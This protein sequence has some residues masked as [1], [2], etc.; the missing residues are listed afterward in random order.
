MKFNVSRAYIE[1]RPRTQRRKGAEVRGG[2]VSTPLVSGVSKSYVDSNFVTLTTD[3]SIAGIKD[4]LN[5]F[6]IGGVSVKCDAERNALIFPCNVLVEGGVAAFSS[7]NGFKPQTITDAVLIDGNTL[8]RNEN[9]EIYVIGGTG[10]GGSIEYP[11]TWSGYSSGS[12]DGSASKNIA[13]PSLLSQ[14]T[15]DAGFATSAAVIVMLSDYATKDFVTSKGYITTESVNSLLTDYLPKSGGAVSGDITVTAGKIFAPQFLAS[16]AIYVNGGVRDCINIATSAAYPAIVMKGANHSGEVRLYNRGGTDWVLTDEGWGN[17]YPI[18]HSGN[19]SEY[20]FP[21]TGGSVSGAVTINYNGNTPLVINQNNG[22]TSNPRGVIVMNSSLS[23]NNLYISHLFG[24][25]GSTRNSAWVGFYLDSTGSNNNRLSMGLYGVDNVLNVLG[26]G[27]VA[28]GGVTA[29]EKLHVHGNA[30]VTGSLIGEGDISASG[31]VR[32]T[33]YLS[34]GYKQISANIDASVRT[35]IYGDAGSHWG[36]IKTFRT[37]SAASYG[38]L[39][40]AYAAGILF[41][42]ADT[43]A[44]I[45]LPSNASKTDD[46]IIGGGGDDNIRWSAKLLHSL[47]YGNYALPITGGVVSGQVTVTSRFQINT[48]NE[49]RNFGYFRAETMMTNRCLLHIGSSY[50]YGT[51]VDAIAMYRGLVGIGRTFTSDEMYNTQATGTRL[52]VAGNVI[53]TGG[54]TA[55]NI[56]DRRLKENIRDFDAISILIGMG[57]VHAYEYV[58][59]E[60]ARDARYAGTHYGFIYQNVEGSELDRM[61]LKREDGYGALN[62]LDSNLISVV[63]GGVLSLDN[64]VKLLEHENEQLREEINRLKTSLS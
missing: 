60:V 64:R 37:G 36:Q 30:K 7:I 11:L 10:G 52:Y 34:N 23:N 50:S 41:A 19:Y 2:S 4:F 39:S 40:G 57:G 16:S 27:N 46:A 1:A 21:I 3:Q 15:N 33:A 9:G 17:T 49:P 32:G 26:S 35:S 43:H 54:V 63:A 42:M 61:C 22:T 24:K 12:Y 29:D 53:A 8:G 62:Y 58:D 38:S 44:F 25:E 51:N 59:T 20:A 13:I 56:S 5:G 28:I 55:Q 45:Q 18:L 6:K 48:S 31:M 47:N 14:L